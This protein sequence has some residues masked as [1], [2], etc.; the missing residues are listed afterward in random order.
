MG[1][2]HDNNNDKDNT[3]SATGKKPL[4]RPGP[5]ETNTIP[6]CS[7]WPDAS[8]KEYNCKIH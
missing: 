8:V 7:E 5:I 3:F 1:N 6:Q 4:W 2:V